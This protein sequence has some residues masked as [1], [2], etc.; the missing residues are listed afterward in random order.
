MFAT[1]KK[2]FGMQPDAVVDSPSQPRPLA[3]IP[4]SHPAPSRPAPPRSPAAPASV[5]VSISIPLSPVLGRLT[6]DLAQRVRQA[7][8]GDT[9]VA[10]STQ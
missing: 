2:F 9:H 3:S 5:P 7:D 6:A 10:I 8:V 4:A 1:F